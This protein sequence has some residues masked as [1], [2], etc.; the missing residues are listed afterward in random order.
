M[1]FCP[2]TKRECSDNCAWIDV[3]YEMN[4]D[5]IERKTVCA[6]VGIYATLLILLTDDT[7]EEN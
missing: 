6:I 4:E 2:I 1:P 5:G 7:Y 3:R